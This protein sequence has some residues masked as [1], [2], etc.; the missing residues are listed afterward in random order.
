[1]GKQKKCLISNSIYVVIQDTQTAH[2]S[3]M[4]DEHNM[5]VFMIA[6]LSIYLYLTYLFI[7]L[8]IYL[9]LSIYIYY[10]YIIY[11]IYVYIYIR[12]IIRFKITR[13]QM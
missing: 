8:S 7:Y 12:K 6:Y 9:Y 1:M 11:I 10:I 13:Q 2:I 5:I 3:Q 4:Q